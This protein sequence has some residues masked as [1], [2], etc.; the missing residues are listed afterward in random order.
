MT[1]PLLVPPVNAAPGTWS[2][3]TTTTALIALS[4]LVGSAWRYGPN[5]Y[6]DV[7]P[8]VPELLVLLVNCDQSGLLPIRT[9][10]RL[11]RCWSLYSSIWLRSVWSWLARLFF[12]ASCDAL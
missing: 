4:V 3:A 6:A 11:S 5:G 12:R 2:A 9:L 7:V 10:G 8:V 1:K